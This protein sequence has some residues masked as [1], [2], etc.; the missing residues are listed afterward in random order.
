MNFTIFL[1]VYVC[2]LLGVSLF[3]DWSAFKFGW[4]YRIMDNE[5]EKMVTIS[6]A[7]FPELLAIGIVTLLAYSILPFFYAICTVS[8]LFIICCLLFYYE[9][10][11]EH[12]IT[13]RTSEVEI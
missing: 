3:L 1:I 8:A 6:Y 9:L 5:N 7:V 13:S 2:S 12:P 10:F 11:T 4:G